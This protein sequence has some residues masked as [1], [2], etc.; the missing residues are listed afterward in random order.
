M[1]EENQSY[2]ANMSKLVDRLALP[3]TENLDHILKDN[4]DFEELVDLEHDIE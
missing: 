4:M 2:F 3:Y 1:M